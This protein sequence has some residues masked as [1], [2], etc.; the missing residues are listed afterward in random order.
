MT[1]NKILKNIDP[2][3][4]KNSYL[5]IDWYKIIMAFE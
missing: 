2:I 1:Q 4:L 5:T 3:I